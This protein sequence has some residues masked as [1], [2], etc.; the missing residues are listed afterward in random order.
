MACGSKPAPAPAP[1]TTTRPAAP[2]DAAAVASPTYTKLSGE[3]GAFVD[4]MCACKDQPCARQ[5]SDEMSR[6]SAANEKNQTSFDNLSADEQ[7]TIDG[8]GSRMGDC[9]QKIK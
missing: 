6:W 3:L 8:L 1:T 2:V 9:M 4:A 7:T 5:V